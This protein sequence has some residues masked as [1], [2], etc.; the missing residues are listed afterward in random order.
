M[1]KDP[2]IMVT[3]LSPARWKPVRPITASLEIVKA[4]PNRY[5]NMELILNAKGVVIQAREANFN[6]AE[7]A[8]KLKAARAM[9]WAF[10]LG[11]F[12]LELY[13]NM[14][15]GCSGGKYILYI[16]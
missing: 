6:S 11:Y 2:R 1:K 5:R 14:L 7:W 12:G 3:D 8:A 9:V 15:V 10:L 13:P 16:S 4:A